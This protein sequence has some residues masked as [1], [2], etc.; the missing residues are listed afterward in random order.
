MVL[1][2]NFERLLGSDRSNWLNMR[3]NAPHIRK[4]EKEK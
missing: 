2:L 3:E 4:Y 1:L